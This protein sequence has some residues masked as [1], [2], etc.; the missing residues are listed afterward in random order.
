MNDTRPR[1]AAIMD[2][3]DLL[4]ECSE[5]AGRLTRRYGT[6][7]LRRA[8][9]MVA[10]WMS[11][12]GMAVRRDAA[13]NLIGRREGDGTD[14]RALLLGSHLDSVRDAG[15]YD[16]PLGV[17]T[18]L[19]AV[20]RLHADGRLLPFPVEVIAFAD[21]EGLR[22]HT[23][24]LGSLALTG[25]LDAALLARTDETGVSVADAM[26]GFGGDPDTLA[27]ARRD[28]ASLLG[29]AEVHIEQGPVLEAL[30]LP[31][32]VVSA[33]IGQIRARLA[34]AGSAGHAGTVPMAF[35]RDALPAA[36]EFV[37]AVEEVGRGH[38][39][40]VATVGQLA[41]EPGASNVIP[42]RVEVTLDLRH[43]DGQTR[44]IAFATLQERAADIA[45]RRGLT[46]EW[47]NVQETDE[48]TCD[49]H[50]TG[51][52]ERALLATDH[53]SHRL[54]SGAGHDAVALSA[55]APV[56]MLFVRCAG[57]ISH[58]PAESV[59]AADVAVAVD[60]V[61]QFVELLADSGT[62]T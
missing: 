28:P 4:A 15:R 62:S 26:R 8:Q 33:I 44:A 5:E 7:A 3:C 19:A 16:G 14:P 51:L 37:L 43:A 21:E 48:I 32:G 39:G 35:R 58:N 30:G 40:M 38:D 6:P 42:G 27:A 25:G 9:D 2:R 60:V 61:D 50:L 22:F 55:I 52:L 24:Y 57:G 41:P 53:Q 12:A 34:F 29:Y 20:E 49:P 10:G 36:A 11:E 1:A 17:L 59:T 23:T 46:A 47:S 13:G 45:A 31:A 56:A 54:V 18:A